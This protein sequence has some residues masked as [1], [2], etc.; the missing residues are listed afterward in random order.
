LYLEILLSPESSS[1]LACCLASQSID[2]VQRSIKI[3]QRATQLPKFPVDVLSVTIAK[4]NKQTDDRINV[5]Q[6]Q[7]LEESIHP[8]SNEFVLST[9]VSKQTERQCTHKYDP[10]VMAALADRISSELEIKDSPKFSEIMDIYEHKLAAVEAKERQLQELLDAKTAALS[11]SDRVIAQYRCRSAQSQAEC[12][13]LRSLLLENQKYSEKQHEQI[14]DMEKEKRYFLKVEEEF[15]QLQKT[16]RDFE[17]RLETTQH[18]LDVAVKENL[19]LKEM[20][21]LVKKQNEHLKNECESLSQNVKELEKERKLTDNLL[22]ELEEKHKESL[23][24]IVNMKQEIMDKGNEIQVVEKKMKG[25]EKQLKQSERTRLDL[26]HK[27]TSS[28]VLI[29]K[30]EKEIKEK[31]IHITDLNSQ[32]EKHSQIAAMIHNLSGGKVPSNVLNFSS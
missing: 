31:D 29:E 21:A 2:L 5:L 32:L 7:R 25:I 30:Y 19:S 4:N 27:V 16:H 13:K 6:K 12:L 17:Q 23:K 24:L 18:N 9:E 15:K 26:S 20:N 8:F 14:S 28:S 10:N 1:F 22:H 11:Q 3:I